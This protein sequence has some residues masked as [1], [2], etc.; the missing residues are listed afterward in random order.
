MKPRGVLPKPDC[1]N[2]AERGECAR[3][4]KLCPVAEKWVNQDEDRP[5][6]VHVLAADGKWVRVPRIVYEHQLKG[7]EYRKKGG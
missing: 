7:G 4:K 5:P 6:M 2:C 3:R 1:V